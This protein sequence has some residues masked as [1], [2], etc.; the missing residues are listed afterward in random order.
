MVNVKMSI[1]D[2]ND[3]LKKVENEIDSKLSTLYQKQH[4][5]RDNKKP[6]K[7]H[8]Q[9]VEKSV[10]EPIKKQVEES[11]KRQ[12]ENPLENPVEKLLEEPVMKPN[13]HI[14][15]DV[16]LNLKNQNNQQLGLG[17]GAGLGEGSNPNKKVGNPP[18]MNLAEKENCLSKI[19]Q[20]IKF[21]KNVL[22]EKQKYLKK[23]SGD[24]IF[25]KNV[26]N[27]YQKYYD[28][29]IK[30]KEDQLKT[31]NFLN[32]YIKNIMVSSKLTERDIVE[33]N[34]EQKR[35]LTEI[36]NIRKSLEE[37]IQT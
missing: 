26:N 21:K 10:E 2:R 34:K 14:S 35:V 32:D 31:L 7:I 13:L 25:L 6:R 29:I 17:S 28:F 18:F 30:Q 1:E 24:N 12:V 5:H 23:T 27:D 8:K 37:I 36:K 33:T 19:E 22:I 15:G 9:P 11:V 16:P 4:L 20:E 3:I